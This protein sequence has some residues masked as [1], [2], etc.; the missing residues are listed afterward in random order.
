MQLMFH[1]PDNAYLNG[2]AMH[3][4]WNV[5]KISGY[6]AAKMLQ[7][8]FRETLVAADASFWWTERK[9]LVEEDRKKFKK[10]ILQI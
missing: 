5:I 4:M 3:W 7:R 6:I 9:L 8:V 2:K 10:S 1:W